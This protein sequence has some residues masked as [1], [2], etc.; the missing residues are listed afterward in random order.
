MKKQ[1]DT[2]EKFLRS[3]F[4]SDYTQTPEL[5]REFTTNV[6]NAIDYNLY[7]KR[8]IV[9]KFLLAIL[10]ILCMLIVAIL[11]FFLIFDMQA[12]VQLL[13]S[14]IAQYE[15]LPFALVVIVYLH[16]SRT[17][18]FLAIFALRKKL[19]NLRFFLIS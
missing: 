2:Q 1:E 18:I 11:T 16:F 12:I 9:N 17:L 8:R 19:Q 3:I 15:W 13:P 10:L 6:M 4:E 14:F 7:R 5:S